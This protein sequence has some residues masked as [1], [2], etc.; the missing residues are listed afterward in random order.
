MKTRVQKWSNSLALRIPKPLAI[1][2]GQAQDPMQQ[3]L[4][5]LDN[6]CGEKYQGNFS[7]NDHYRFYCMAAF[8]D[9]CTLKR[10]QSSDAI[11]KLRTSSA[12]ELCGLEK[13]WFR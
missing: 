4:L 2:I 13:R 1:Q 8:N 9:Y 10:A 11:S 3:A 12:T 5:N 7:D 6:V